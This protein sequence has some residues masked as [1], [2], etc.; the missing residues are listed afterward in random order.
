LKK[1]LIDKHFYSREDE[2]IRLARDIQRRSTVTTEQFVE[3]MEV[4]DKSR[5]RYARTLKRAIEYLIAGTELFAGEIGI[6]EAKQRF[7]VGVPELS[8]Q[9]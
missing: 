1:Y 8:L 6:A 5:S 3:A 7:D 2:L 9:E 4:T